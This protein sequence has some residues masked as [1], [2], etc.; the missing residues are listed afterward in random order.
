MP[1]WLEW[2][3]L[4]LFAWLLASVAL[5]LV[6]ARVIGAVRIEQPE[7]VVPAEPLEIGELDRAGQEAPRIAGGR[8]RILLVDDDPLLRLLLRTTLT[9]DEFEVQEAASA[10][11]AADIARFWRPTLVLLDVGLPGLDGLAFCAELKRRP[12]YDSPVVI[13]L[14]GEDASKEQA[15][16]AGADAILRKP[17]SPLELVGLIDRLTSVEEGLLIERAE[18]GG[19]GEQLIV[20]AR[21][22][23]S[24]AMRSSSR[25]RSTAACSTTPGSSTASFCTTSERSGCPI[26][27]STSPSR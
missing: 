27:S 10:E 17:F 12:V 23:A 2:L 9:T 6:L 18:A 15:K 14:T 3:L 1:G 19:G 26:A 11:Q 25:R 5:S 16:A 13:L 4:G 20:Y 7:E 21:D 8:L 22:L 24:N